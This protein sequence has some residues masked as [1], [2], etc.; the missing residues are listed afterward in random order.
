MFPASGILEH[1]REREDSQ[2]PLVYLIGGIKMFSQEQKDKARQNKW[3]FKPY[4]LIIAFLSIGPFA[5]PFLWL[6]PRFSY[7][8]KIIIS[9]IAIILSYY[10]ATLFLNSLHS[11]NEYYQMMF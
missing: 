11:I 10:L 4:W 9:I 7:K 3:Y 6:N 2:K 5:L 8:T 1:R